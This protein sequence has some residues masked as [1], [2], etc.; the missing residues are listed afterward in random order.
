MCADTVR[1]RVWTVSDFPA[2]IINLLLSLLFLRL[3]P[4]FIFN[5]V[6]PFTSTC[7]SHPHLHPPHV[8]A[9]R[10]VA[11]GFCDGNHGPRQPLCLQHSCQ[12]GWLHERPRGE[13]LSCAGH[14][15]HHP[16]SFS[17]H[18]CLH[19][20][21]GHLRFSARLQHRLLLS[22]SLWRVGSFCGGVYIRGSAGKETYLSTPASTAGR[23]N[24]LAAADLKEVTRTSAIKNFILFQDCW[25]SDL[26]VATSGCCIC[27]FISIC[28]SMRFLS[29]SHQSSVGFM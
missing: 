24:L 18:N 29:S 22:T 7:V 9:S 3:S 14:H 1:V 26:I 5:T 27:L 19:L 10:P 28:K 16:Q 2:E 23:S 4:L 6:L 13:N 21:L 11:V 8:Q 17:G 12:R 20:H 25:L 15:R